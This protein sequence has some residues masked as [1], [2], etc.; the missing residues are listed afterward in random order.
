VRIIPNNC[1]FLDCLV[2]IPKQLTLKF[3]APQIELIRCYRKA[4]HSGDC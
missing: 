3:S 1:V 2:I 4:E